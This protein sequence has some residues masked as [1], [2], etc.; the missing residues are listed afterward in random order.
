MSNNI[1]LKPSD[2]YKRNID[3]LGQYIQQTSFYLSKMLGEDQSLVKTKLISKI[4]TNGIPGMRDPVVE[5]Y[6]RDDNGDKWRTQTKLSKYI[7]SVVKEGHILIPTFT[8][9]LSSDVL[10]SPLSEFID[11]NVK[12][13]SINKKAALK[14]ELEGDKTTFILKNNEQISN[15][16]YNNSMSGGFASM[17]TILHNPT[18]HHTLT[19]IIRT[20]SSL[21]NSSNEKIISG[22]RHYYNAEVTLNNVISIASSIDKEKFKS[23]IDKYNLHYPTVDDVVICIKYSSDLYWNDNSSFKNIYE[24]IC[25]LD[26]VERAAIVYIS[27]LYHI[28]KFNE[29]FVRSFLT[30]LSKKVKDVVVTNPLEV[31]KIIDDAIVNFAHQ[32]CLTEVTGI[33][34]DYDKMSSSDINTLVATCLNIEKT[35]EDHKDFIDALFLTT[36]LPASTAFIPNMIR[37][38]VVLSDT[39]STMFSVDEYIN[40]YFGKIIFTDEAFGLASSVMFIATQC[41]AHNLAMFSANMNVK[42]DKLYLLA[43]KPEF[44]FPIFAQTSAAKH[45][46]TFIN[47]REGNVF[48]EP[49]LEIKGVHLINS[50]LP[51]TLKDRLKSKM[52]SILK[53]ILD[54]RK[55][56]LKDELTYVANIEREI[57]E[58]LLNGN[59]EFFK[60]N[61][62]KSPEAYARDEEM[63]PYA[64]HQLWIDVF[65]PKYGEIEAPPY[66]VIKIPTILDNKTAIKNWLGAIEDRELAERMEAWFIKKKKSALPTM[67][68]SI[69]YV[70]A[71]GIPKE[72]KSIINL[73]KIALDLTSGNRI[74]LESLGYFSKPEWLISELGY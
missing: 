21:G 1:F 20:V 65:Q 29:N 62:I 6:E 49:K 50:A 35:I 40:W 67:Y 11:L 71:F 7:S 55:I 36:N 12:R 63:S 8:V 43:M 5:H 15:K 25:K 66:I 59:V 38:A 4:R 16:N 64:N 70:K 23:I 53:T 73:K 9:N 54:N 44:S 28:R 31:L 13:R 32:I 52:D 42:K 33:G 46:Y 72:I 60:Q 69:L 22:N 58:S 37:R 26:E 17:G 51:K 10:Q 41:I 27:D 45:Y 3:P 47:V 24:F 39:D 61:K 14:A 30:R 57:K 19:S 34:K 74:V 56:K 48:K 2:F 18:A 68:L